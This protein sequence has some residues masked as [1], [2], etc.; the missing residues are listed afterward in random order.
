MSL[1]TTFRK[2]IPHL[3]RVLVQKLEPANKT[4]TGIILT[5]KAV[6]ADVGKIVAVGDGIRNDSGILIPVGL[7]VGTTVLLPE[8][9]G[10][11]IELKDG[12]FYLYRESEI[13][14][15]LEDPVN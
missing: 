5:S 6:Q 1:T 14:G 8:F 10:T 7:K 2:F 4:K 11:K 15:I 13:V 12:E 9:S 3:N